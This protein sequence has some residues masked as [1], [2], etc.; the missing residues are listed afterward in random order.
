MIAFWITD[1]ENPTLKA[2]VWKEV[3]EDGTILW[4]MIPPTD[5]ELEPYTVTV[6]SLIKGEIGDTE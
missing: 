1:S 5:K 2:T 4:H 6:G 3:K